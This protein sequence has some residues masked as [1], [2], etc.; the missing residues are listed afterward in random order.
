MTRCY[1]MD[2]QGTG[3]KEINRS[4]Q[5]CDCCCYQQNQRSTIL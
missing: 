5:K 4:H 1:K 2:E 3:Q